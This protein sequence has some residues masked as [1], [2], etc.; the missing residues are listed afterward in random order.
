M[1]FV[2]SELERADA[3]LKEYKNIVFTGIP[4]I[5]LICAVV[6]FFI[7]TPIWRASIITTISMLSVILLI[8][9]LAHARI[10]AYNEQLIQAK[11]EIE[12]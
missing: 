10:S 1:A 2:E 8:D 3:T 4:L 11:Q 7:N 5:I 6:L 12:K 9:G